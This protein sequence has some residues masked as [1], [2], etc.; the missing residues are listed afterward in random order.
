MKRLRWSTHYETGNPLVDDAHRELVENC[1]KMIRHLLDD[2][3]VECAELLE[4][5]V[6]RC[7][8][9]YAEEI[10]LLKKL[11]YPDVV[12]H[13]ALHEASLA[14]L[15]GLKSSCSSG[16][17]GAHCLSDISHMLVTHMLREDLEISNAANV[18]NT[19]NSEPQASE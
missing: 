3:T 18:I 10:E 16:C 2:Q 13:A 14:K 12:R 9:H 11:R 6:A 4:Q 19:T 7:A 15:Q 5:F 17:S 8:Q 1:D